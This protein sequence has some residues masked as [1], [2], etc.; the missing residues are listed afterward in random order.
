MAAT[1]LTARARHFQPMESAECLLRRKW[2]PSRNQSHVRTVSCP[3][4]G[5]KIA[6]SSPIP[7]R[8][9]RELLE[10]LRPKRCRIFFNKVSSL[11]SVRRNVPSRHHSDVQPSES[12]ASIAPESRVKRGMPCCRRI[13][14]ATERDLYRRTGWTGLHN[15]FFGQQNTGLTSTTY[16][17]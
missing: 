16:K 10:G 8:R 13:L 17:I 1:S 12:R 11:G 4:D 5:I 15:L 6:A 9:E 3:A 7:K 14:P 2:V